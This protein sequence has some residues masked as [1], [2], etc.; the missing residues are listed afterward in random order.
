MPNIIHRAHVVFLTFFLCFGLTDAAKASDGIETAGSVL[1]F[2]LPAAAVGLTLSNHDEEG[3]IQLAE[4]G[5]VTLGVTY[6]L[7][8]TVPATRPNGGEHSFPSG[9]TSTSFASAEFIRER[10]GWNYG[11]P[12]YLAASFVGYSRVESKEHHTRDVIAGAIIGI[13]SSWLF[14]SPNKTW[15]LRTEVGNSF[16]GLGLSHNW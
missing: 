10:Y 15:N 3:F 12:A 7:K 2:V 5:I 4:S 14:T 9:H 8:Y 6:G 13:G 1:Q 11:I 16:Y